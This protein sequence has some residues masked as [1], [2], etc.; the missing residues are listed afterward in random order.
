M[1]RLVCDPA[2]PGSLLKQFRPE[3]RKRL[4]LGRKPRELDANH[5]DCIRQL[6]CLKCGLEGFSQAAHVRMNQ[7]SLGK[8]Q[9]LGAKPDDR[10]AVP[11]CRDCHD[12]QHSQGEEMFWH[13]VGI[14][15][16][17]VAQKLFSLSPDVMRMHSAIHA[18]IARIEQ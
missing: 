2:P 11:L 6:P 9:A 13:Q 4:S 8:K 12:E 3:N 10:W 16:I 1:T 7:G 14:N 5:L 15:P 17:L 18:F